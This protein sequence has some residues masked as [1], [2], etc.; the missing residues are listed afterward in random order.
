MH[1]CWRR[2]LHTRCRSHFNDYITHALAHTWERHYHACIW[3]F[4][5]YGCIYL[6]SI[7][8][9]GIDFYRINVAFYSFDST[10]T[11][12]HSNDLKTRLPTLMQ[13]NAL[14]HWTRCY[15]HRHIAIAVQLPMMWFIELKQIAY[16]IERKICNKN[17][18]LIHML[19]MLLLNGIENR[20][21]TNQMVFALDFSGNNQ[22]KE[23]KNH[24]NTRDT[25]NLS[26]T[27]TQHERKHI[28][29]IIIPR[30]K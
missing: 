15:W 26:V 30:H 25:S 17:V 23:N 10:R 13:S 22:I 27:V 6:S 20:K 8:Q 3:L 18:I 24:E 2:L 28:C 11:H 29:K 5:L 9:K 12:T 1:A 21:R 14:L 16:K 4:L 7:S 19:N